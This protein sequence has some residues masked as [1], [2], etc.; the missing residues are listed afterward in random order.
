[1]HPLGLHRCLRDSAC[2]SPRLIV[3]SLEYRS[4]CN[5]IVVAVIWKVF[6][7]WDSVFRL[8]SEIGNLRRIIEE[9]SPRGKAQSIKSWPVSKCWRFDTTI[10][11]YCCFKINEN[12]RLCR[13][14]TFD[15]FRSLEMN[16]RIRATISRGLYTQDASGNRPRPARYILPPDECGNASD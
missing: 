5:Q 15:R 8:F 11:E 4:T 14:V 9:N 3:F 13:S 2:S 6:G 7:E 1:M 16:P 12:Q 10:Q